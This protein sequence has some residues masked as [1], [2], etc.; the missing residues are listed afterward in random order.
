MKSNIKINIKRVIKNNKKIYFEKEEYKDYYKEFE[1]NTI[2]KDI[3]Y[4]F[5]ILNY[6]IAKYKCIFIIFLL[7]ILKKIFNICKYIR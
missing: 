1:Y 6:N 3:F 4:Y 7:K 2:T 5:N